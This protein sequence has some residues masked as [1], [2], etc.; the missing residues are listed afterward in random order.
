MEVGCLQARAC[1]KKGASQGRADRQGA[2]S[3]AQ[4]EIQPSEDL[5]EDVPHL[6]VEG[7]GAIREILFSAYLY[8]VG[9][10][11]AHPLQLVHDRNAVLLQERAWPDAG[12][13]QELGR[14]E[15]T[16]TENHLASRSR[17]MGPLPPW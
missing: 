10:V 2:V 3:W 11:L 13:L 15:R 12:E 17:Q 14:L 6:L 8:V 16:G 1:S 4:E 5:T 9:E 7:I